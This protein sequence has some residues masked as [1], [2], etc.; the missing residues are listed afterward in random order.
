MADLERLQYM[1]I[2]DFEVGKGDGKM[3]PFLRRDDIFMK[4]MVRC[5]Q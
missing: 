4:F 2:T 3:P 5:L 1:Y